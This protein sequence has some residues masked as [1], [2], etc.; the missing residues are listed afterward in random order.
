MTDGNAAAR[1]GRFTR[2]SSLIHLSFEGGGGEEEGGAFGAGGGDQGRDLDGFIGE[3]A[4]TE[5]RAQRVWGESEMQ[6]TEMAAEVIPRVREEIDD[7]GAA[8]GLEDAG[9]FAQGGLR[10]L[11]IGEDE[12]QHGGVA[13]GGVDG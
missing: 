6:L 11:E 5:H 4:G 3:T 13:G 12:D 8:G 9:H 1:G 10:V 2:H 7:D